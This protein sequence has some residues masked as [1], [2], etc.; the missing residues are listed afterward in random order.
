[1]ITRMVKQVKVFD[2][3]SRSDVVHEQGM[4]P[5]RIPG[6]SWASERTWE[7]DAECEKLLQFAI[8]DWESRREANP[9]GT[10]SY[11]PELKVYWKIIDIQENS[12]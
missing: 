9:W 10:T 2:V 8:K 12:P 5:W 11:K 1:M 7:N 6:L 4:Q 3:A